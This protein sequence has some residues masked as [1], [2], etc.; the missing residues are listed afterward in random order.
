MN[1][2]FG[3]AKAVLL[4]FFCA[5]CLPSRAGL[6][7]GAGL[8]WAGHV[9]APLACK[10]TA[11]S[12]PCRDSLRK[13]FFIFLVTVVDGTEMGTLSSAP[14]AVLAGRGMGELEVQKVQRETRRDPKFF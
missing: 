10:D 5:L 2:K 9:P 12:P 6:G 11:G 8:G 3:S 13:C 14:G 1:V 4:L 7:H